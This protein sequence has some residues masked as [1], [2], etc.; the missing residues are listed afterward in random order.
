MKARGDSKVTC[1]QRCENPDDDDDDG[2]GR[3]DV[4][5]VTI[6]RGAGCQPLFS[7]EYD[8]DNPPANE[9]DDSTRRP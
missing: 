3:D 1:K 6:N 8:C 2:G 4:N 9:Y 5:F 7:S